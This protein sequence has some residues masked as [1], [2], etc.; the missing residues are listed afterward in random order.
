MLL[1]LLREDSGVTMAEYALVVSLI[2]IV[3]L[4]SVSLIGTHMSTFYSKAANS[5]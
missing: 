1:G 5:L 2:A 4:T 3:C